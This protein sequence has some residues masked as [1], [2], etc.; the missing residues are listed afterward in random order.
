MYKINE[1]I[2]IGIGIVVIVVHYVSCY[3]IVTVMVI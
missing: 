2:C 3:Y 1:Y